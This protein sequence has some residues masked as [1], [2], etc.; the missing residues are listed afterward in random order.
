MFGV[1]IEGRLG[2]QMFQYAFAL[3]QQEKFKEDFYLDSYQHLYLKDLFILPRYFLLGGEYRRQS[4]LRKFRF[5][6]SHGFRPEKV[7]Q[8][9]WFGAEHFLNNYSK[10]GILYGGFFQSEQYFMPVR[11]KVRKAFC[12]KPELRVDIRDVTGNDRETVVVH[13]RRTDYLNWGNDDLQ[14]NLSLPEGYY[15]RCLEQL[16]LRDKNLLFLS[17]DIAYVKEHFGR[18]G[19]FFSERGSE[20][21]DLQLLMQADYLVLANSSFSWWGAWLNE[22][23]KQ[24]FAPKHWLGFKVNKEWPAG[25]ISPAWRKIDVLNLK[26]VPEPGN[27]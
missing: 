21:H 16:D 4:A 6:L 15:R 8:D 14:Y 5:M 3:A 18:P 22:R 19:A 26:D 9:Q 1:K 2:N 24:V 12:V 20:I 27:R 11:D 17:D 7:V 13:V 10:P 23:A 25:V